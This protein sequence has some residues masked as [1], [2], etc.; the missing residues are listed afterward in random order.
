M[1]EQ[2]ARSGP[3]RPRNQ[4]SRPAPDEGFENADAAPSVRT[5]DGTLEDAVGGERDERN[6]ALQQGD[7]VRGSSQARS[8]H[9][10][11]QRRKGTVG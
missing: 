2:T 6:E 1:G 3:V 10:V 8:V 11:G 7:A 9:V 5:E 4:P